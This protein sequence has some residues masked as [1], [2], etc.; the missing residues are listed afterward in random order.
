M[1]RLIDERIVEMG[2]DN[3]AF[4]TNVKTSMSTIDKLKSSLNFSGVSSAMN[5]N[6]SS[7]DTSILA[8]GLE[9]ASSG[10]TTMEVVAITAIS[11]ITNR[12]IDLGI[13]MVKSLSTDNISAGF[14]KYGEKAKAVGTLMAQGFKMDGAG[15]ITEQLDKLSWYTD[16][17]SYNFTDMIATVGKFTASGVELDSAVQAVMGIANWAA[18][19]AVNA[20]DASRAMTQLSQAVSKGYVGLN[21]YV[22][23][24]SL[25]M[26]TLEFKKT[27]L[28]TA[29]AMGTL[30]RSI[31]G[32]YITN[33]GNMFGGAEEGFTSLMSSD[34][35]FTS[36]ILTK[37]LEKYSAA[38]DDVFTKVQKEGLT[39]TEVMNLYGD[40]F[41][42]FG[43]K[44]LRAAQEARTFGD[45]I[46]AVRDAVTTGWSNVFENLFGGYEEA[47]V[48]WS[49][50]SVGLNNIFMAGLYSANEV[51]SAWGNLGGRKDL[52][53]NTEEQQGAFWNLFNAVT[54]LVDLFKKSWG[55]IFPLS[56]MEEGEARITDLSTRLKGFTERLKEMSKGLF[57][58]EENSEKL[59]NILQGM[60]S[61]LKLFGKLIS[62]IWVGIQPLLTLAK[63]LFSYLFTAL[64]VVGA[65]FTEFVRTTDKLQ[66]AGEGLSRFF[67]NLIGLIANLN[68]VSKIKEKFEELSEVFK[69]NGG[70]IQNYSKILDG[71]KAALEIVK[72]AALAMYDA[73]KTYVLPMIQKLLSYI[74]ILG[75]K[76]GGVFIQ[77]LA[78]VGD[79]IVRFNEY[80]KTNNTFQN[81]IVSLVEFMKSI[82]S[83]LAFLIPFM[84]K[85]KQVLIDIYGVL[86]R[87]PT[88]IAGF[89]KNITGKSIGDIF[90]NI[91]EKLKNALIAIRGFLGEFGKIDT[92]GVDKFNDDVTEKFRPLRALLEGIGS[93]FMGLWSVLKAVIPV[94]GQLLGFIGDVLGKLGEKL[95]ALFSGK[96]SIFNIEN[97]F[98]LAFWATIIGYGWWMISALFELQFA[99]SNLVAGFI[100][101]LDS[102]AMMQYA[103]A[104]KSLSIAI[105]IIVVALV[106][107]ASIDPDRLSGA[108][109][110]LGFI[111]GMLMVLM[112][113]MKSMFI[114]TKGLGIKSVLASFAMSQAAD[115][116]VMLAVAVL[117][118]TFALKMLSDID[119]DSMVRGLIGLIGVITILI[120]AAKIMAKN[121]KKIRDG[122]KG[123]IRL[124][125]AVILLT[126]PLK[127]IGKMNPD[128][129]KNGLAGVTALVALC[130]IFAT[131]SSYVS[132]SIRTAFGMFI[133]AEALLLATIPL[134]IIGSMSVG[135]LAKGLA[136]MTA[137][138]L[139]MIHFGLYADAMGPVI[140]VAFG[141]SLMAYA[142]IGFAIALKILGS[143]KMSEMIRATISLGVLAV[144]L[145]G[146]S[147]KVTPSLIASVILLS[148]S[149]ALLSGSLVLFGIAMR[150]MG[151]IKWS[152]LLKAALSLLTLVGIIYAIN[153]YSSYFNAKMYMSMSAFGLA[154]LPLS[155]GLF[156]FGIAM[157]VL[158]SVNMKEIGRSLLIVVSVLLLVSALSGIFGIVSPLIALFGLAL[159][160]LSAG[161][162]MFGLAM[163]VLGSL[164][165]VSLGKAMLVLVALFGALFIAAVLL[166]P[167][168][169]VIMT[170]ALALFLFAAA[171]L[172][173]A[174]AL[175][176]IITTLGI[177]GHAIGSILIM[178]ADAI[179]QAGPKIAEAISM[180]MLLVLSRLSTMIESL[181][182]LGDT[183]LAGIL[184]ILMKRGP[185]VIKVLVVLLEAL[186]YE[187]A[188]KF[189]VMA[190]SLVS[191]LMSLLT[192]IKKQIGK[193]VDIVVDLMLGILDALK[194]RIPE[195][196]IS[197]GEMVVIIIDALVAT[198]ISMVPKLVSSAF[199]LIVGL[200][201]GLGI[202]LEQ[203][204]GRIREAMTG[205]A[206][207]MWNAFLSFFGINK[208]SPSSL[209]DLAGKN[210]ILGLLVGIGNGISSIVN[211]IVELI[212]AIVSKI[213]E[214]FAEFKENG[215]NIINNIREGIED[216][217]E[218]FK[219][220]VKGLFDGVVGFFKDPIGT[221]K[222]IGKD[223]I[224]GLK[225]GIEDKWENFKTGVKSLFDSVAGFFNDP[226]G[227]FKK[228]GENIVDG[229]KKGIEEKW[230]VLK[231]AVEEFAKSLPQW[232]KDVLGIKSP[233]KVF[234]EIGKFVDLGLA[235]GLDDNTDSIYDSGESVGDEAVEG[236]RS[237]LSGAIAQI[238]DLIKAGMTDD[239]VIKPVMDLSE[240]QNGVL[241]MQGMMRNVDNYSITGS[242]E[243][244]E[245]TYKSMHSNDISIEKIGRSNDKTTQNSNVGGQGIINNTFNITGSNPKAIAEEVSRIIQND[246]DRRNAKWG[247]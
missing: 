39:A 129:L 216:R 99:F 45:A 174:V 116:M 88:A 191:M 90:S 17:T 113:V 43:L 156:A 133:F 114:V 177:F 217:W 86:K 225:K 79:A 95:S 143:M 76:F 73:F 221:F 125:L 82:P 170:L 50:L 151:G 214:K 207:H 65:K 2:F 213:K 234:A 28:D 126:I 132:K 111:I 147:K 236:V 33:E 89:V 22:S 72:N 192:S 204:A 23:V 20:T 16:E 141:L 59:S 112:N 122:T 55:V 98:D 19:S 100:N 74:M 15:G 77:F 130:L 14:D 155:A 56:E 119:D 232:V 10:F 8:R 199:D 35:W 211:K 91:G 235:Q 21:D 123:M 222:T 11:N 109:V 196:I 208:D 182:L 24:Q 57:L 4:E 186:L 108:M 173:L 245:K 131:A 183:L 145:Y 227:T 242:N 48:F 75:S 226:I 198:I 34:K 6:L 106:L 164:K 118:L 3:K 231:N 18:K 36:E 163:R 102:K 239:L 224:D 157:R 220:K 215:K 230:N 154:L 83:R 152:S 166:K 247:R 144:V 107:L 85:A 44:A 178:L 181:F 228:I 117:L 168:V 92:G 52:F 67:G 210:I 194:V 240:I 189:P 136:G 138:V 172:M 13:Q 175:T 159:I 104:L 103:E 167:T 61:V 54:A 190:D 218:N 58:S 128:E 31:D 53:E 161:L 160:S 219:T 41:D 80:T 32:S 12:I 63:M 101:I 158:G 70:N 124:A 201:D 87:I 25:Q 142:L 60:F 153:K 81:G 188:A 71:L 134:K 146:I 233:S 40:E 38:T 84:E 9:K 135:D 49:D 200:I 37:T 185:E 241:R 137:I 203:N 180:V 187:L 238:Y 1:S 27:V 64:S 246:V 94:I 26:D 184:T 202:A 93:L 42:E 243:V 212:Q 206:R 110:S 46:K 244:A 162:I 171:A 51:L 5:K 30:R 223:I 78:W 148:N 169:P 97:L 193:I 140:R 47:T 237:G 69:I 121:E 165:L 209:S 105:L 120:T 179:I 66:L 197:I 149:L 96:G 127:M 62:A 115:A 195:I 150:V 139:L 29:V 229:I 7:V 176:M 205:L 68:I